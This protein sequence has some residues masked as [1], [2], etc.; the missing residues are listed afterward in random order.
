MT[1]AGRCRWPIED[2]RPRNSRGPA[3]PG[4]ALR[5]ADPV[6][7]VGGGWHSEIPRRGH[8]Q[9]TSTNSQAAPG[10]EQL[11]TDPT[12]MNPP[13]KDRRTGTLLECADRKDDGDSPTKN[14]S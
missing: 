11:R 1:G 13:R 4:A 9:L 5:L 8:Q 3:E 12:G 10:P 14:E 7:Q 2:P 6:V